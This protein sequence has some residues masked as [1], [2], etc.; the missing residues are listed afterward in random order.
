MIYGQL[1]DASY[2]ESVNYFKKAVELNPNRLANHIG[3]GRA[4]YAAMG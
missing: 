1:P 4:Q 2:Q 3:L